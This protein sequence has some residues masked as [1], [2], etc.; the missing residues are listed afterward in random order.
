MRELSLMVWF[1]PLFKPQQNCTSGKCFVAFVC[2]LV[3][4]RLI[5]CEHQSINSGRNRVFWKCM[6]LNI[7]NQSSFCG[8]SPWRLSWISELFWHKFLQ[9][10]V[11]KWL[12]KEIEEQRQI[13]KERLANGLPEFEEQNVDGTRVIGESAKVAVRALNNGWAGGRLHS[14]IAGEDQYDLSSNRV[15]RLWQAHVFR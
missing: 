8:I 6:N 3:L 7:G 12:R 14:T 13:R 9:R 2:Y 5:L 11:E 1:L 10:A 15:L 4:S